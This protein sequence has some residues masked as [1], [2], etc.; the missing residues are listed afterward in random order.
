MDIIITM[1]WFIWIEWNAWIFNEVDPTVANC[2]RNFMKEITLVI[3][4]SKKKWVPEMQA[5]LEN[6]D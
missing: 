2:K 4:R 5:W 3:Q 6:L 1:S